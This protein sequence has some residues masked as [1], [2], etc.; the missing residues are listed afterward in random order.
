MGASNL[1]QLRGRLPDDK[2]KLLCTIDKIISE[3]NE[4]DLQ[5]YR[6]N[7]HHL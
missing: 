6:K 5:Q 7:L 2:E 4:E 1:F 3:A